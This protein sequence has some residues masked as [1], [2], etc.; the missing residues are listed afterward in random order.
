MGKDVIKTSP[1]ATF[2]PFDQRDSASSLIKTDM[3]NKQTR[4]AG[5]EETVSVYLHEVSP[6]KTSKNKVP[7]FN[8][9]LQTEPDEYH[10]AVIFSP[11]KH[12]RFTTAATEKSAV[13]L[14]KVKRQLSKYATIHIK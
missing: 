8:A 11:D 6:I 3:D 10:R 12:E 1:T 7:Y 9:V 2:G 13:K 14:S 5:A 4:T